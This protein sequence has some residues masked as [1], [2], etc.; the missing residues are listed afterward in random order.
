[1]GS[2]PPISPGPLAPPARGRRVSGSLTTLL[3]PLIAWSFPVA[4]SVLVLAHFR[5]LFEDFGVTGTSKSLAAHPHVPVWICSGILVTAVVVTL[6]LRTPGKRLAVNLAAAVLILLI[7]AIMVVL[8]FNGIMAA[9]AGMAP[10]GT[11]P[12]AA[13]PPAAA[14]GPAPPG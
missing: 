6:I 8:T 11:A 1:M 13:A 2:T 9:Q 10:V 5:E 14:P 3:I 7:L 12:P 4:F